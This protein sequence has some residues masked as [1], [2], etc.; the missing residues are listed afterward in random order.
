MPEL[1]TVELLE[2]VK[3][4]RRRVA[5]LEQQQAER[6]SNKVQDLAHQYFNLVGEMIIAIDTNQTV[7]LINRQGSLL[8]EAEESEIIG[9][10]WFD[11]FLP[12]ANRE[13]V[14]ALFEKLIQGDLMPVEYFENEIIT[15]SGR[16]KSIAWHNSLLRDATDRIIGTLSVGVDITARKETEQALRENDQMFRQISENINELFW[17]C[18][19]DWREVYYASQMYEVIWGRSC[20]SLY[21][22]PRSCLDAIHPDDRESVESEIRATSENGLSDSEFPRFRII[23]KDGSARWMQV[24][25][26]PVYDDNHRVTRIVGIGVDITSRKQEEDAV[27]REH[28]ELERCVEE[29]TEELARRTAQLK[30]M[31]IAI[32]DVVLVL[33]RNGEIINFNSRSK[34]DH[35]LSPTLHRG[36]IIW[37]VLPGNV[38]SQMKLLINRVYDSQQIETLDY[39]LVKQEKKSWYRAR[40]LPYLSDEFLMMIEQ[41]NDQ[42]IAEM[43]LKDLHEKLSEAQRLAHIGSWE[44]C[45]K[46]DTIWW[47]DEVYRIFGVTKSDII[48]TNEFFLQTIHPDDRPLVDQ[49]IAQSLKYDLPYSIEH[50]ILRPDGEVRH[51]HERALLK[52]ND[53]GEVLFMHGTVQDMTER[54]EAIRKAQEYRDILAHASRLA[55]MGELTAG[56]SHELNQPLTAI[57]NYTAAMR[58]H[59]N[60][61]RE[62]THL[63]DKIQE[64]SLRSGEIVRKLKSLAE[65]RTLQAIQFNIQESIRS[66]LELIQYELRHRQIEVKIESQT[67]FMV[68]Y[69]DRVQIEQ[70]LAN[71]FIN[72][73]E[74][75]AESSYPRKLTINVSSAEDSM[76]LVAITDTGNGV[77][78][79]FVDHLFTPFTTN[80][81]DGLG[82]GLSLSRS[83]VEAAGGRIYYRSTS[84]RGACF[85]LLLPTRPCRK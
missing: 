11:H 59:L 63:V 47:S 71:L 43:E 78:E 35:F 60:E 12:D 29:R 21:D 31:F 51:V 84:E 48:L 49:M 45:I 37:S 67:K 46:D 77:P 83:L 20:Q 44:W 73:L 7:N 64:L 66:A 13:E 57:A 61:N 15:A 70:V 4:L 41:I 2:E 76:I 6:N 69:A 8:L 40:V 34:M 56:I 58:Q 5:E 55:V 22:D 82:I 9:K 28:A 72:A 62:M 85:H 17:V 18:S 42:K 33:N 27:H 14:R 75:M 3:T 53:E 16:L 36:S 38:R 39:C 74:A 65:K 79:D 10:N 68:V 24:R 25:A 80:K 54:Y 23:H 81:K 19:P 1:T 30:A 50:R 52:K 26:F 32:P